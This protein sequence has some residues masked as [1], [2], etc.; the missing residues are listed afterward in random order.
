MEIEKVIKSDVPYVLAMG[1]L[2]YAM[3]C[4]R[5]DIAQA[6]RVVSTYISNPER[7]HWRAKKWI[8]R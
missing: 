4:T 5:S 3:V 6:V 8:L 1:S 7:E 2:M